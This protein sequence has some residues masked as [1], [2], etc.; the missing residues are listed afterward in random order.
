MHIQL[1]KVRKKFTHKTN[2]TTIKPGTLI[3]I[4][5]PDAH[6]EKARCKKGGEGDAFA[7]DQ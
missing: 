1:Y 3:S 7:N 4:M 6:N 5:L 2:K